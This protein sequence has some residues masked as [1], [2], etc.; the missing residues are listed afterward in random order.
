MD[1][2]ETLSNKVLGAL[3]ELKVLV[4]KAKSGERG[5]KSAA[6]QAR[7]LMRALKNQPG[8]LFQEWINASPK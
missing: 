6:K 5:A 7:K 3:D 1:D 8:S 4:E 2:F